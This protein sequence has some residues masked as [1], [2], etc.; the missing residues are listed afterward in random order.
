MNVPESPPAGE[1]YSFYQLC[2]RLLKPKPYVR[3]LQKKLDLYIPPNGDK[4][5][6]E[7]LLFMR[8][9][10]A[11]RTYSVPYDMI[12]ALFKLE[13]KIMI[14][15]HADALAKS[16]DWY[17]AFCGAPSDP[18]RCLLLTN[19]NLDNPISTGSV[20]TQLNFGG[21]E[22]E[23]FTGKDMG[24]DIHRILQIYQKQVADLQERIDHEYQVLISALDWANEARLISDD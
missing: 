16:P 17:L 3:T 9:I 21:R 18:D 13:K 20:Q 12:E 10:I 23:L 6:R 24:E 15:L 5:S 11:L 8:K 2:R 4:Y 14:L 7:Y 19:Y 22:E 1:T